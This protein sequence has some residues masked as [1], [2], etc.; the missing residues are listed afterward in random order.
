MPF[1]VDLSEGKSQKRFERVTIV[2]FEHPIKSLGL[3]LS[4]YIHYFSPDFLFFNQDHNPRFIPRKFGLLYY[5]EIPLILLGLFLLIK[6][7]SKEHKLILAWLF[8]APIPASLTQWDHHNLARALVILP[9][10]QIMAAYVLYKLF[11]WIKSKVDSKKTKLTLAGLLVIFIVFSL[12]NIALF[13]KEYFVEYPK[14]SAEYWNYGYRDIINYAKEHE[15][16]YDKLIVS[17]HIDNNIIYLLFYLKFDPRL[18]PQ[19]KNIGFCLEEDTSFCYKTQQYSDLVNPT[20]YDKGAWIKVGYH[21]PQNQWYMVKGEDL[22]EK[23]IIFE[24]KY[25]DGSIAVKIVD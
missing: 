2:D 13:M 25:P 11:Y 7:F 12:G 8:L 16:E 5:F 10:F 23:R 14:Y 21:D 4:N 1:F 24:V 19:F 18:T 6:K 3:F 9:T 15:K 22:P 17:G 20:D